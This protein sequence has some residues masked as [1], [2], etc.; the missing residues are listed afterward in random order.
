[1]TKIPINVTKPLRID[2]KQNVVRMTKKPIK[3]SKPLK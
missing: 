2:P 3:E 1:M